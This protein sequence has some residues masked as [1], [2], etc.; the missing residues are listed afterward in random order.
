LHIS[1]I[2]NKIIFDYFVLH[3]TIENEI[4]FYYFELYYT[5][6]N[7]LFLIQNNIVSII[8]DIYMK[9]FS[10]LYKMYH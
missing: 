10:L 2:K 6:K 8:F 4:Q 9:I 5:I 1:N 3:Y 7:K